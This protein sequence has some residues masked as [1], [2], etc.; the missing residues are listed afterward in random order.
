MFQQAQQAQPQ[1][2][3]V[4]VGMKD[5]AEGEQAQVVQR[6]GLKPDIQGRSLKSQA[7]IQE[8]EAEQRSQQIQDMVDVAGVAQVLID[9]V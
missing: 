7:I 4:K 9:S 8:K 2:L 6:M 1:P 3:P 5:L